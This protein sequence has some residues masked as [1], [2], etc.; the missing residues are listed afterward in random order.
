MRHANAHFTSRPVAIGL[1]AFSAL[2]AA[3]LLFLSTS[4]TMLRA[5]FVTAFDSYATPTPAS[6]S[7]TGGTSL[8]SIPFAAGEDFWLSSS[9]HRTDLSDRV[10]PASWSGSVSVGDEISLSGNSGQRVFE[11]IAITELPGEG[12]TRVLH[13]GS[14]ERMILVTA[15]EKGSS[16]GQIIR[17]VIDRD[18]ANVFGDKLAAAPHTL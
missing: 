6:T 18:D 2:L 11:I 7:K 16:K 13:D 4:E 5:Q 1:G 17:F 14:N 15:R 9:P 12:V 3:G 8:A 10:R